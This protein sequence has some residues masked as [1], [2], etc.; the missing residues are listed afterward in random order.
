MILSHG[1]DGPG[2]GATG[3]RLAFLA[4]SVVFKGGAC[5]AVQKL[6]LLRGISVQI[7]PRGSD[8][9]RKAIG[10]KG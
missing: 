2:K 4:R 8:Q 1:L 9:S 7:P 5:G 3:T 10:V 6:C